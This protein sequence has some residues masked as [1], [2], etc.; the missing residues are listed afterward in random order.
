M[1]ISLEIHDILRTFDIYIYIY[2]VDIYI[3]VHVGGDSHHVCKCTCILA[4]W[5]SWVAPSL[6]T[7][8][9]VLGTL[10]RREVSVLLARESSCVSVCVCVCVCAC[11]AESRSAYKTW[12]NILNGKDWA[13]VH[14]RGP[15]E[16]LLP[17]LMEVEDDP[18][19]EQTIVSETPIFP[20]NHDYW[21]ENSRMLLN[22]PNHVHLLVAPHFWIRTKGCWVLHRYLQGLLVVWEF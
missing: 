1:N 17:I 5:L 4:L 12:Y 7:F 2:I 10:R 18:T 20:L 9:V 16:K 19:V 15:L 22:C 21:R 13:I 6:V 11:L 14:L 8:H 3:Y